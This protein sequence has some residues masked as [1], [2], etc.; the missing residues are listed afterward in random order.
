M[1]D[2][3][4]VIDCQ[5]LLF[6]RI[7]IFGEALPL[8]GDAL[9]QR[10][11]GDVL[12]AFH[13][14]DEPLLAAGCHRS[15]T[16]PAVTTDHR[17]HPVQTGRFEQPVPADLPVV[18]GVDVD[19]PWRHDPAGGIDALH[20][21]SLKTA[22]VAVAAPHFDDHTVGDSDISPKRLPAGAVHNGATGDRQVVHAASSTVPRP[23]D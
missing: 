16:D 20:R 13:Q 2:L 22:V 17:G 7:K 3:G 1:G 15:E 8:P 4:A 9:G 12:D 5:P 11:T 21:L 19:E 18:V 10:R 6:D 14:F 23:S